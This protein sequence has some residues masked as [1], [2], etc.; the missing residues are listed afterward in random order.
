[1]IVRFLDCLTRWVGYEYRWPS[2]RAMLKKLGA[3]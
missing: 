1:M 2:R 3:K